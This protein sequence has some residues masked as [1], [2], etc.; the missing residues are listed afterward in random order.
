MVNGVGSFLVCYSLYFEVK[1]PIRCQIS[2]QRT[3]NLE[4][5][6]NQDRQ[7]STFEQRLEPH[8][9]N[10]IF[11]NRVDSPQFS[12]QTPTPL[13]STTSPSE[14]SASTYLEKSLSLSTSTATKHTYPA[15]PKTLQPR[16]PPRLTLPTCPSLKPHPPLSLYQPLLQPP[17][18]PANSC[19]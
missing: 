10:N 15:N 5:K 11:F 16:P 17:L 14:L 9:S 12:V 19:T 4:I 13:K 6:S 18:T 1:R 8:L 7:L 3:S 2:L